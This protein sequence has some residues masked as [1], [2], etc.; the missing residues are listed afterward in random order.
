MSTPSER[1]TTQIVDRLV[2][3][4]LV[5]TEDAP[6]LLP[7]I[8]EGNMRPEDWRLAVENALMGV[9]ADE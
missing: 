1:L 5:T 6:R 2:A 7:R 3:E 4:G 9:T 8:E